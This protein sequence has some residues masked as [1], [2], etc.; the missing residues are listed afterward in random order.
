MK[1]ENKN[2]NLNSKIRVVALVDHPKSQEFLHKYLSFW[3]LEHDLASNQEDFERLIYES[4]FSN[5]SYDLCLIDN[6]DLRQAL[7]IAKD[8]T[9]KS[10]VLLFVPF[11][12]RST[13]EAEANERGIAGVITKPVR[14]PQLASCIF[15]IFSKNEMRKSGELAFQIISKETKKEEFVHAKEAEQ[16]L[17]VL[18]VDDYIINQKVAV[19]LLSQLGCKVVVMSNG[20]EAFDDVKNK[21]YSIVFMDCEMPVMD[22]FTAAQ[23]I[24]KWEES[25]KGHRNIIIALTGNASAQDKTRCLEAGMDDYLCK[26]VSLANFKEKLV[27]YKLIEG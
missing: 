24:R 14:F 10:K 4:E 8:L 19:R 27:K 16:N 6:S 15:T 22:G 1:R 23:E 26:P 7:S 18:V 25:V 21:K 5:N 20:Q 11:S 3:Q 17:E 12:K 13:Y 2:L 9:E